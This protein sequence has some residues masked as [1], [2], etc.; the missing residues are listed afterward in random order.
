MVAISSTIAADPITQ[1]LPTKARVVIVENP[2]ATEAFQPRL[3]QVQAMV[4]R[5]LTNLLA[6]TNSRAAWLSLITTQDTVGIK[7]YS[8]PGP[9]SGTRP[10]VVEAIATSL[11][12]A[13][14]PSKQIIV[15]DKSE[16]DLRAAGYFELASRLG[17]RAAASSRAGWDNTNYYDKPFIGALIYGDH[18]FERT[19]EGIG[20]KSFV[21]KLVSLE[22]T[23]IINVPP[24]LNHNEASVS[25]NLYSLA[26]GSVD[27]TVRFENRGDRLAE[28]VPEIYA[29]P[30]LGDRVVLNI[31]DALVCQYEG[32]ARGLLHYSAT[33]DQL[34]FSRDPVALDVLSIRE[35]ERQRRAGS[36]TFTK[37][38]LELYRNAALLELGIADPGKIRVETLR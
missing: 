14:L 38:N 15:W 16:G 21:S 27:N 2:E 5:G 10:A 32:G 19:G 30:V 4:E 17:I 11:I 22:M 34:R 31:V 35:L 20:R 33:L 3:P 29:L 28:A 8:T 26:M 18:E 13:G 23:K 1:P 7:V 6:A 36:G 37:P 24:L 9:L 25:G 12:A